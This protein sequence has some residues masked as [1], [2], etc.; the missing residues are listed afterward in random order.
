MHAS[1]LNN[2]YLNFLIFF[3]RGLLS[4]VRSPAYP[5]NQ[6]SWLHDEGRFY[7]LD[8]TQQDSEIAGCYKLRLYRLGSVKMPSV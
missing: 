4:L 6:E 8:F 1:G 7:T 2:Y 3:L 5:M